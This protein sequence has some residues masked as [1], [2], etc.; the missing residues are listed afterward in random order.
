MNQ[1]LFTKLDW[2]AFSF[3]CA[4]LLC[5]AFAFAG[6]ERSVGVPGPDG[7]MLAIFNESTE[8]QTEIQKWKQEGYREFQPPRLVQIGGECFQVST[9]MACSRHYLIT[10]TFIPNQV[11]TG[12]VH[13]AAGIAKFD[14]RTKPAKEFTFLPE[15]ELGKALLSLEKH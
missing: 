4:G 10:Q 6:S 5:S 14:P 7:Q 2:L 1:K 15:D 3:C 11:A 8:I 9:Y 13:V 12:V